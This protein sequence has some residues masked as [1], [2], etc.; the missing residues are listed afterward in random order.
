MATRR[1]EGQRAAHK[2][3]RL[4]SPAEQAQPGPEVLRRTGNQGVPAEEAVEIDGDRVGSWSGAVRESEFDAGPAHHS[5]QL[6]GENAVPDGRRVDAV[7]G[8]Q[9]AGR[10]P[11]A[12]AVAGEEP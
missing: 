4:V 11:P 7:E 10:P 6:L 3:Q 9:A 8:E 1:S 5:D 12:P 2:V